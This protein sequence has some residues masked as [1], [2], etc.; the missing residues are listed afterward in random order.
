MFRQMERQNLVER[1]P[2][3]E[4]EIGN[5][6]EGQRSTGLRLIS[7]ELGEVAVR[8]GRSAAHRLALTTGCPSLRLPAGLPDN[9]RLSLIK[10][11]T[12]T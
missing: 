7:L 4:R 5:S 9:L 6:R 1:H 3:N 10:L 2:V 8:H 11:S 12:S